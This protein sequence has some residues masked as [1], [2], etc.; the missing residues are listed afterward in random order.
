M[1]TALSTTAVRAVLL[2]L[3]AFTIAGCSLF[4]GDDDESSADSTGLS[5]VEPALDLPEGVSEEQAQLTVLSAISSTVPPAAQACAEEDL[6]E[7]PDLYL[8]IFNA[9][10]LFSIT[11]LPTPDQ[12]TLAGIAIECSGPGVLG[13][14]VAEGLTEVADATPP[15]TVIDCYE[16]QLQGAQADLVFVGMTAVNEGVAP[17]DSARQ[18]TIAALDQCLPASFLVSS[19]VE[20]LGA[21]DPAYAQAVDVACVDAAYAAAPGTMV[22]LWTEFV[23]NPQPEFTG[24]APT[25]ITTAFAPTFPCLSLA[26]VVTSQLALAGI[27]VSD[28]SLACIDQQLA[29]GEFY[30]TVLITRTIDPL[31]V[32]EILAICLPA[33]Q[34]AQL[35][36]S[37]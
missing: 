29:S 18:P 32:L 13:Q 12:V 23:A 20:S 14:F 8:A 11:T 30:Q 5:L 26:G 16:T 37:T 10:D 21:G 6:L 24:V 33:E 25:T 35:G 2:A 1:S 7:H 4:G 9:G 22:P 36:L 3:A 19:F 15:A 27:E 17:T 31:S 34:L 28:E